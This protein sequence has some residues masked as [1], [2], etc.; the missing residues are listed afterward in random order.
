VE[1]AQG[2]G[3]VHASGKQYGDFHTLS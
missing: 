3:T 2:E 1:Q